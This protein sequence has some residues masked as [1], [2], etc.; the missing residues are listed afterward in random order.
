MT[1]NQL[2]KTKTL[3]NMRLPIC[4]GDDISNR[5]NARLSEKQKTIE[6][7]CEA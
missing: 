4:S 3:P 1:K 7:S 6:L 2:Y 5:K